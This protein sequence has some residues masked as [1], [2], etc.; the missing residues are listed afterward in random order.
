MNSLPGAIKSP[1]AVVV[2][3]S[4]PRREV[5]RK[6]RPRTATAIQIQNRVAHFS[7]NHGPWPSAKL[8]RRNQRL[9][10][11]PLTVRHV[12]RVCS[13][14][15]NP[16]VGSLTLLF[17]HILRPTMSI[18]HC[19]S[20]TPDRATLRRLLCKQ[21]ETHSGWHAGQGRIAMETNG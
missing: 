20:S 8:R 2:M 16:C 3:H 9:D 14:F 18:N 15:H 12:R 4:P 19:K 7:Q 5:V 13:P 6:V 11:S 10:Q 17:T 21:K 1:L